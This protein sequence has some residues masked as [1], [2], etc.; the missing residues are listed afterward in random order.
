MNAKDE[1]TYGQ[2]KEDEAV[3]EKCKER[4]HIIKAKGFISNG[5]KPTYLCDTCLVA[6]CSRNYG[7]NYEKF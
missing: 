1:V 2:P 3:C 5:I 6:Y 4:G 7:T